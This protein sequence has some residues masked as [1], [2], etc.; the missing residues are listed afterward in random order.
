MGNIVVEVE[1]SVV[2]EG[3]ELTEGN[4]SGLNQMQKEWDLRRWNGR[5]A[6]SRYRRKSIV[7]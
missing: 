7:L 1:G 6:N 2:L 5:R 3:K 4:G